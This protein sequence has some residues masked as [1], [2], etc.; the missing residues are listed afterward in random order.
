MNS[1]ATLTPT[2]SRQ[3]ERALTPSLLGMAAPAAHPAAHR[4]FTP[5]PL[6]GEGWGEG[7]PPP[8][9]PGQRPTPN[10]SL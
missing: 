10:L 7:P 3:Q 5:S 2:L 4:A 8:K 1:V 6:W 9:A